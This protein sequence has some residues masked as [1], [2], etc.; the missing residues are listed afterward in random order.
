MRF[1]GRWALSSLRPA[2]LARPLPSTLRIAVLDQKPASS[3]GARRPTP[4]SWKRGLVHILF[5]YCG[6]E[7]S[8]NSPTPRATDVAV[9]A[10]TAL[11]VC[12]NR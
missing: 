2:R 10:L 11:W 6:K 4:I 3:P 7:R 5:L 12:E 9:S 8:F 1:F